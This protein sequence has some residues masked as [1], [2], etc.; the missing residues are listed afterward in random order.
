M[1]FWTVCFEWVIQCRHKEDMA[2]GNPEFPES[3]FEMK[4]L[5]EWPVLLFSHT[6]TREHDIK[7]ESDK[8]KVKNILFRTMEFDYGS[9]WMEDPP[10]NI[11][12][13]NYLEIL[14]EKLRFCEV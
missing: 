10:L 3:V 7:L 5:G 13:E 4:D 1:S 8:V 12:F 9:S 2:G 14:M 6:K 11:E